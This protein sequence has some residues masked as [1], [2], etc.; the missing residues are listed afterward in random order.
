MRFNQERGHAF[1]DSLDLVQ[2]FDRLGA[3]S[4]RDNRQI[5]NG[6]TAEH[7]Y[8]LTWSNAFWI[9]SP[10][11]TANVGDSRPK[12]MIRNLDIRQTAGNGPV[13][14][15]H[16]E[17]KVIREPDRI[18]L[19]VKERNPNRVKK[20]HDRGRQAPCDHHRSINEIPK[21]GVGSVFDPGGNGKSP[22]V[23]V[24]WQTD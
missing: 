9:S 1:S 21:P 2:I 5:D 13:V 20:A 3:L 16:T 4:I 22:T 7:A 8:G 14:C 24:S 18:D 11:I 17:E 23:R 19:H 6:L 10:Y 15:A 12:L